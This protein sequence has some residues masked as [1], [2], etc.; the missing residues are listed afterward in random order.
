[1]LRKDAR[2]KTAR[3]NSF[4]RGVRFPGSVQI[5]ALK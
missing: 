5:N 2:G 1:M 4:L 3:S